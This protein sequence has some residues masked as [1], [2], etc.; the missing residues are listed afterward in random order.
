LTSE[1]D[2]LM[3]F[4]ISSSKYGIG[5]TANSNKTPL[6][7][8]QIHSKFG[9]NAELGAIFK[10]RINTG[11]IVEIILEERSKGNDFVTSRIMWLE[12]LD[13]GLNRGA[14]IDSYSRYIYIHGTDEEGLIGQKASHGCIRMK[15]ADVIELFEHVEV[16][17]IVN[18]HE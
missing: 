10:G 9:E 5:N 7:K 3:T 11:E 17:T 12:G 8:H 18:I 15:N 14:G 4:P 16:G 6:G 2:T 1:H 13:E